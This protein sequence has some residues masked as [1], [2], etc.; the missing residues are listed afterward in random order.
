MIV[1]GK[2]IKGDG[3]AKY[4]FEFKAWTKPFPEGCSALIM[5][6]YYVKQD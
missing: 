6:G 4:V 5:K 2:K 1:K 3:N